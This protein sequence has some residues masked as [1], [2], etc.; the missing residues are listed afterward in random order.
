MSLLGSY[1]G[2][3]FST[4]AAQGPA[5]YDP[6]RQRLYVI[7][8]VRTSIEIL[9]LRDPSRPAK[10]GAIEL[11]PLGLGA[12][13][14]AFHNRTLAVAIQGPTKSS[15]GSVLFF[16]RD[17]ELLTAPVAGRRAAVDGRL[18]ARRQPSGCRQYRRSQ[19]GLFP[20]PGGLDQHR[21]TGRAVRLPVHPRQH[22]PLRQSQRSP[23]RAHP[24]RRAY[25]RAERQRRAGFGA[26]VDRAVAG[27]P[28]RLGDPGAQQRSGADRRREREPASTSC[29]S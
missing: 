4:A 24:G 26:G 15:P 7:S 12:Q 28:P 5:A 2:G 10:V 17:G 29:R 13:S 8:Q 19:R 6:R 27:R 3:F 21:L 9:D 22:H 11:G 25:H 23:E 14:V 20:G 1:R 16:D 18:Y